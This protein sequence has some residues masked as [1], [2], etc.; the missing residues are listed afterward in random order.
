MIIKL[1]LF[2]EWEYVLNSYKKKPGRL[3]ANKTIFY[4]WT[5]KKNQSPNI[6]ILN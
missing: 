6:S 4:F 2:L 1:R 3:Q 5:Q